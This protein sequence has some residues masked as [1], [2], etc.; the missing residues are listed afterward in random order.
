MQVQVHMQVPVHCVVYT[1]QCVGFSVR[2][3]TREDL[4]ELINYFSKT[5]SPSVFFS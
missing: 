1:V 2:P 5:N 4:E 3:A